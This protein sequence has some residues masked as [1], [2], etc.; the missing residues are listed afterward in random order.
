MHMSWNN[1]FGRWVYFMQVPA[2]FDWH[3]ETSYNYWVKQK[4]MTGRFKEIRER[5]D[6]AHHGCYDSRRQMFQDSIIQS[7][8]GTGTA[9]PHPWIVFTAG[10]FFAGKSW[11]VSWMLD[12]GY[13]PL[14]VVRTDP[15][16]IRTQLPEW[17]GY[18]T[19]DGPEAA[20][21]TQREAGTIALIAQWEAMRQGRHILVDGSLRRL[22]SK[23]VALAVVFCGVSTQEC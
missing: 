1:K 18:L 15:D 12:Q 9:S 13:L 17:P 5:M 6:F 22:G 8:L 19:R 7:T 2:S 10:S 4:A 20:V 23:H 21:M 3:H 11:V 16:L 14:D